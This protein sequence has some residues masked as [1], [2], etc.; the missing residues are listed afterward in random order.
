MGVG[1]VIRNRRKQ[2][3][4]TQLEL[5]K[6]IG[7]SQQVIVGIEKEY[8]RRSR[9]LGPVCEALA[10]DLDEI[11]RA[12]L[13]PPVSTALERLPHVEEAVRDSLTTLMRYHSLHDNPFIIDE[14]NLEEVTGLI[15]KAIGKELDSV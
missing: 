10:L 15:C 5:A 11:T 6:L 3:R 13:T 12:E 4:M 9:F 1:E 2:M 8:Y 14:D 7:T